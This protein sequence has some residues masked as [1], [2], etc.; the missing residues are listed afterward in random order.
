M[1]VTW[2]ILSALWGTKLLSKNATVPQ[3]AVPRCVY[4]CIGWRRM[5][6]YWLG[7]APV[8]LQ[9][10]EAWCLKQF[11]PRRPPLFRDP[12]NR[13]LRGKGPPLLS[14]ALLNKYKYFR[15]FCRLPEH[16]CTFSAFFGPNF[17]A[18]LSNDLMVIGRDAALCISG[19]PHVTMCH[20]SGDY[21]SLATVF[22]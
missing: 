20:N 17:C 15:L 22:K 19:I 14:A 2:N 9:T 13:M 5:P 21:P 12:S 8:I 4:L 16:D 11:Y 10:P 3:Y 18:S 6:G 1:A 7:M